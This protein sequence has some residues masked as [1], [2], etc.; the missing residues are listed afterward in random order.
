MDCKRALAK[1]SSF[2]E[3][4]EYLRK[5]ASEK[6]DSR[7]KDKI[8]SEGRVIVKCNREY[9]VYGSKVIMLSMLC[10]TDFTAKSETFVNI[11]DGI[12][13]ILLES[14]D[15]MHMELVNRNIAGLKAQTGEKIEIGL[16]YIFTIKENTSTSWY[17]HFD[18]KKA[19]LVQFEAQ[20]N[21]AALQKLGKDIA[22][23]VVATKPKY[24]NKKECSNDKEKDITIP[25]GIENKPENIRM[26]IIN[27]V[28]KKYMRETV[29]LEQPFCIDDSKTINE[30]I[31]E[32]R[33]QKMME[34]TLKKFKH[35]EI[36]E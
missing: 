10:E 12:A 27:G 16:T 4:F 13:D 11:M 6:I 29:L 15:Q 25:K 23:H 1:E 30:A 17:V 8:A 35:I 26:Q 24:L 32:V 5:N 14:E 20:S 7:R 28:L 31:L 36:G 34:I 18:N 3:A 33:R 19:G 22:M 2:D 9:P 21:P